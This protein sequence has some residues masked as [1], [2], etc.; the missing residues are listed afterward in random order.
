MVKG[1]NMRYQSN[2]PKRQFLAGVKCKQCGEIDKIVQIEIFE[3][4]A[5]E[6]IECVSCGYSERRLTLEDLPLIQQQ[7]AEEDNI[8]QVVKF[9]P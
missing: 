2:R 5:D 1:K 9:K 4:V 8:V 6:Y 7:N 3:P